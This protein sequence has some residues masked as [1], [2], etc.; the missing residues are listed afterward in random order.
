[1]FLKYNCPQ[2]GFEIITKYLKPGD[3]L[4]CKACNS[5]I[6][7]PIDAIETDDGP[8]FFSK[9]NSENPPDID[10]GNATEVIQPGEQIKVATPWG[11]WSIV[12]FIGAYLGGIIL[13]SCPAGFIAGFYVA[14]SGI[15]KIANPELFK[16]TSSK[17]AGNILEFV[18]NFIAIGLIYFSVVKRHHHDSFFS[19]LHLKKITKSEIIRY[20]LIALG[21]NALVITFIILLEYLGMGKLIPKNMPIDKEFNAGYGA[22]I[23]FSIMV[24]LAPIP[25]ELICR[26]YFYE[27][28]KNNLGIKWAAIIV[29]VIFVLLHGPQLSF[30]PIMLG[31]ISIMAIA[32]IIIRIKTDSLTKC[33]IVHQIY[34]TTLIIILWTTT[35]IFGPPWMKT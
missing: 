28:F 30:S 22:M 7:V 1:M 35:L 31:F 23:W 24:L 16:S 12:K 20:I 21:I 10:W 18:A 5:E 6:T 26:G 27:G 9:S 32:V 15:S 11:I 3:N 29:T 2:C 34:N 17:Y 33:I 13:F 25:E 14:I 19:A 4:T 8:T